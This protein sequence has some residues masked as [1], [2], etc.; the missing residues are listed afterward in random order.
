LR[1]CNKR[2]HRCGAAECDQQSRRPMVTVMRPSR[3][4]VRTPTIPRHQR[5][6]FT[7]KEHR[8]L[9]PFTGGHGQARE[10]DCE[11]AS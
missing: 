1:A 11:P 4:R 6:V 9:P 2:P 7:F 10:A 3:A 8:M 5:A